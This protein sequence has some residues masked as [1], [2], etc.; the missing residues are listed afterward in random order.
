MAAVG[1][2]R[3]SRL[4]PA[5]RVA[6]RGSIRGPVEDP[7]R[8]IDDSDAASARPTPKPRANDGLTLTTRLN[9]M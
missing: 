5:K 1:V 8:L 6:M 2:H 3:V 4:S 9:P 7:A